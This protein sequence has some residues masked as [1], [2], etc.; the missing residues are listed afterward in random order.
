MAAPCGHLPETIATHNRSQVFYY[1]T[2]LMQR[3]MD[4]APD[5]AGGAPIAHYTYD[6]KT[7]DNL[8]FPTRRLVH[9]RDQTGTADQTI[10]AITL[11]IT[12]VAIQRA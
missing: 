5:V 11:E 7:F 9:P 10:T 12:D 4:Y 2:Q 6:P 3:R 8:V 1:D